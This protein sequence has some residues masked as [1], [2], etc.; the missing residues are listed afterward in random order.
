MNAEITTR[1]ALTFLRTG[2]LFTDLALEEV[3]R[4]M[5]LDEA[6]IL[7]D[8]EEHGECSTDEHEVREAE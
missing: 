1:Y 6:T 5:Q 2:C 8:I 7:A 3:A 4:V